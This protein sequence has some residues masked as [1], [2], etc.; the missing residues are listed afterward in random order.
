MEATI[1]QALELRIIPATKHQ[2]EMA[3]RSPRSAI[4]A[5]VSIEGERHTEA[6]GGRPSGGQDRSRDCPGSQISVSAGSSRS[7]AEIPVIR[8]LAPSDEQAG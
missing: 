5:W 2:S 4:R 8:E 6:P 3:D 1:K 7:G